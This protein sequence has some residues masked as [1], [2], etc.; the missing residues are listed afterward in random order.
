[1]KMKK[2]ILCLLLVLSLC[3]CVIFASCKPEEEE[4]PVGEKMGE[5]HTT[6]DT[7]A[8]VE[9]QFPNQ[10]VDGYTDRH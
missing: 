8:G 6:P 10:N 1:M 9:P 3:L 2:S 5:V 4:E 7:S